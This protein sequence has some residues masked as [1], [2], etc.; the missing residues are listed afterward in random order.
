MLS[1]ITEPLCQTFAPP[2]DLEVDAW[3][4]ENI[5][6]G[7]WS[8][9]EGKFSTDRTPWIVEPLRILGRPGPRRLTILGPAA[10]GKSTISEVFLAWL[11]DNAP[12]FCVWYAQDEEAAKEFAETRV[13]R[14][15]ASCERVSRWFPGNRH[16]KRTQ[17]IHFPH[18]SFV[19]QAANE[20]NAQSKHIRHLICDEPWM[21]K[22]GMLA[23]LHK[24][25]TRFAHNRTI[26]ETSTGS[27]EGDEVDQAWQQGSRQRWQIF[28][29]HCEE[30]HV[31][32]WTFDRADSP[33][34]VKWS[35]KAKRENGT[36]D[37]RA[38]AEST[39]YQCPTCQTHHAA[40]SANA[41]IVNR[42]GSYTLPAA[43]SMPNHF[44]FHWNCI[45]SDFSQLGAIAVE[46]LMAKQAIKR[47]DTS[48]FQEF[49]QKKL[50]EAWSGESASAEIKYQPSDYML[51]DPWAEEARR[52]LTIDKQRDHFWAVVRAWSANGNSR[53]VWAGRVSTWVDLRNLQQSNAVPDRQVLVD[54]G[55]S[56][57][58][59]YRECCRYGWIAIKGE[60]RKGGYEFTN[61]DGVKSR[62]IFSLTSPADPGLGTAEQG[63]TTCPLVLISDEMTSDALALFRS[64]E[65]A[66]WTVAKDTP[67]E[68]VQQMAA[69]VK[70]SR[71]LPRTNQ[72]VWEWATVGK[73][74]EHLW[75]CERMQLA[76]AVMSGFFDHSKIITTEE[77]N[78]G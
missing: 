77:K 31:P 30:L 16:A 23:Q 24:R 47:G 64:G 38:V 13:Q 25:T 5:V 36:W 6:V 46:F 1:E 4:R 8:P 11:I 74:G 22:P 42:N 37:L 39:T 65:V 9:W 45:A 73:H 12:G 18:M 41:Y 10:G 72:T 7:A 28:C 48:L 61:E 54:S 78:E 75:D 3:A 69:R 14:F 56:A 43:D 71:V 2:A 58:E 26:I 52:F 60:A 44:S 51:G 32:R 34:G 55:Y 21:Y 63:M 67:E 57:T 19:I 50:A 33:G 27:L 76:A 62:R 66:G 68:H 53:L 40:T 29:P 17:A 70:R 35:P 20:G 59:V 49:T 15:L